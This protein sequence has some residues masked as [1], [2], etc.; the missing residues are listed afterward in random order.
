MKKYSK[1]ILR[2]LIITLLIFIPFIVY[3]QS[4][5][6]NLIYLINW[7]YRLTFDTTSHLQSSNFII[8][9]NYINPIGN[10]SDFF[11]GGDISYVLKLFPETFLFFFIFSLLGLIY[12]SYRKTNNSKLIH[13]L[14][15]LSFFIILFSINSIVYESISSG[16][17]TTYHIRIL[18]FYSPLIVILCG[19]G[20]RYTDVKIRK[21]EVYLKKSEKFDNVFNFLFIF[22]LIIS[23][24]SIHLDQ[25]E[26]SYTWIEYR[27][28][29]NTIES[30]FY[31]R[32]TVPQNSKIMVP[33]FTISQQSLSMIDRWL[34]DMELYI[35]PFNLNT[36]FLEFEQY[37]IDR[38]LDFFLLEKSNYNQYIFNN[39]SYFEEYDTVF[40]NLKYYI[41]KVN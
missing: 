24:I 14:C 5:G 26:M 6:I 10:I 20:I 15:I 30:Y 21:L 8:S 28:D 29:D 23:T 18:T 34:Y 9:L 3:L 32:M 41:Y 33:N 38:N 19:F 31:L 22:F 2:F 39:L 11:F 17:F 25:K 27:Y 36:T 40:E 35:S 37:V 12:K 7:Y 4:L 1:I 13:I 16:F